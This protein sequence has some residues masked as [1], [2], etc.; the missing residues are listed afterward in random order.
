MKKRNQKEKKVKKEIKIINA[1]I[2]IRVSTTEQV[3]QGYSLKAQAELLR[4][5]LL[6]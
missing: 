3:E 2:Y 4:K 6:Q 5:K 1:I